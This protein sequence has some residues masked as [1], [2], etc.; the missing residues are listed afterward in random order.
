MHFCCCR[1]WDP[2]NCGE[3][4]SRWVYGLQ[5]WRTHPF[6]SELCTDWWRAQEDSNYGMPIVQMC[7]LLSVELN[8]ECWVLI[9]CCNVYDSL[10]LK[11]ISTF[12]SQ[13][14][15][16]TQCFCSPITESSCLKAKG[17]RA[18][19]ENSCVSSSAAKTTYWWLCCYCCPPCNHNWTWWANKRWTRKWKWTK[20]T[21]AIRFG[22]HVKA[23]ESWVW[24]WL[25]QSIWCQTN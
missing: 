7:S 17:A 11:S 19:E 21:S 15:L 14:N 2:I 3:R 23:P 25:C 18:I 6:N 9:M 5:W 10:I 13:L 24:F 12:R 1:Y 20:H 22:A 8:L 16:I 4:L